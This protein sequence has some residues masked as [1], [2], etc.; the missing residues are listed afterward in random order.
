MMIA[1]ITV[2]EIIIIGAIGQEGTRVVRRATAAIATRGQDAMR[3]P[4]QGVMVI[5]IARRHQKGGAATRGNVNGDFA[6]R[7]VIGIETG[8]TGSAGAAVTMIRDDRAVAMSRTRIGT[9]IKGGGIGVEVEVSRRGL[10]GGGDTQWPTQQYPITLSMC[11][12]LI[13]SKQS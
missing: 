5:K 12:F 8:S 2:T 4:S 10:I 1:I 9:E 3:L 13:V 11:E 6:M 7:A